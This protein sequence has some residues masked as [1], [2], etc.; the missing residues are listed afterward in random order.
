MKRL[1]PNLQQIQVLLYGTFWAISH[2]WI[3][4]KA[5][6]LLS[7]FSDLKDIKSE[8]SNRGIFGKSRI[9][10]R[11]GHGNPLQYSCLENPHGQRRLAGYSRWDCKES[12]MTEQLSKTQIFEYS[13]T[14]WSKKK[15]I[16]EKLNR[17]DI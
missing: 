17:T 10:G 14:Y 6:R 5:F 13:T 7:M 4:L 1:A 9:H 3:N 16:K 15:L 11:G 8:I 12:D 2:I